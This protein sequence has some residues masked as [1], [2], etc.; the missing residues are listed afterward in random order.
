MQR[1]P[2]SGWLAA[3]TAFFC[4]VSGSLGASRLAYEAL[5]PRATWLGQPAAV[6]LTALLGGAAALW[7]WRR[8]A[9]RAGKGTALAP[10]LPLLL[11]LTTITGQTVRLAESRFLFMLALWLSLVLL[12]Q[13]LAERHWPIP[14]LLAALVGGVYLLTL[15][16]HVGRADSF[17]FQVTVPRLGIAHPT[18]YPLFL[19]LSKP[20]T[21]LPW[22]T[23]AARVNLATALFGALAVLLLF[24]LAWR[25]GERRIPAVLAALVFAL[26]PTFWSQAVE[27]EVYTLH[28]LV[29]AA[30]LLLMVDLL[31]APALASR[32]L[33]LLAALLGLGLANHLTTLLLLPA[34][35]LTLLFVARRQRWDG[36]QWLRLLP[37]L[38]LAGAVPLLLYL[39]LPIRWAAVNGEPMGLARFVDWVVGGRF[40]GALQLRAWL[41]DPARYTVVGRLLLA[42]WQPAELLA[43][44]LPGFVWLM[45]RQWRVALILLLTWLAFVFYALNYY[46]PDLNVFLLPAQLLLVLC[47][48]LGLAA[49]WSWLDQRAGLLPASAVAL[50][51]AAPLFVSAAGRWTQAD[52]SQPD[53]RVEWAEGVLAQPLPRGAAILADS[54]SFPPLYYL[55]QAEGLRS[56]LYITVLPDEAAYRTALG[57]RLA[58]GQPVY[59]ARFLPGLE[60]QYHL[61][62]AGPL[63]EVG[64]A[65][66]ETLPAGSVSS[67][68]SFGPVQLRGYHLEPEAAVDADATALTL[69]W[70]ALEAIPEPLYIYTRWAGAGMTSQPIRPA[71]Q[72]PAGN[73]YPTVAWQPGEVV[74]DYHLLPRPVVTASQQ[75]EIQ[76]AL[77]PPFASD[78]ALDWQ[79][80]AALPVAPPAHL[81]GRQPLRVSLGN[82]DLHGVILPAQARPG[83]TIPVYLEGSSADGDGD[84]LVIQL[85]PAGETPLQGSC[86]RRLQ[87]SGELAPAIWAESLE[88]PAVNG[89]YLLWAMT[90]DC[91]ESAAAPVSLCGWLAPGAGSCPLAAIEVSGVALPA[92]ATNYGD[93]IAL[94]DATVGETTL[95]PGGLLPVTLTWQGLAPLAEDYTV[96]VQ[97]VDAQDRIVGQVDSWP[98]Q[99]TYPTSQWRPGE[100]IRDP[101]SVRLED[102]L[103]PGSYRLLVGWYLLATGQRL[104]VLDETGTPIEDKVILPGL[105]VPE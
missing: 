19:L 67:E 57:A 94:L 13:L 34:A 99:G 47:W 100:V 7:A 46:V 60:G 81:T 102:P 92:G 77:A 30:A 15:G 12:L 76:V 35:G 79:T 82:H 40:Q 23:V 54:E 11:P 8:L 48:G 5:F 25:I 4:G 72:H 16:Q 39:Y 75:L 66:W 41:D 43:L 38:L 50:L 36:R 20:F 93:R 62:S 21:W 53:K 37:R 88:A 22:G 58:A 33:L 91:S 14:L 3:A 101:Y 6:V 73:N 17:E 31:R 59:L 65:P 42:E 84:G 29:V 80:V 63:L 69:Y 27:A 52:R 2:W 49:L 24:V 9:A 70:Q 51:L 97:I 55:Q 44:S 68:L 45:R 105:I 74:A 90:G 87:P 86:T 61:R 28:N 96:F 71:G 104:P 85:L 83:E 18:G 1:E 89:R 64:T 95:Q 10:F 78:S 103:P 32:R 56:D 26:A 98:L